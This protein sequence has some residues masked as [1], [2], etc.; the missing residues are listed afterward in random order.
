[1]S[2]ETVINKDKNLVSHTVT[3]TIS[4]SILVETIS[5]TLKNTDYHSGMNALWHFHDLSEL[6]ISSED[7]KSV[8][9]YASKN[10]DEAGKHYKLALVAEEDLPYGLTRAYEAWCSGRP[11]TINN[12]RSLDDASKW[13]EAG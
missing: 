11:V 5:K 4:L 13:L 10:I 1:M 6:N 8:A 2:V 12:F 7:L 9:E 3:D